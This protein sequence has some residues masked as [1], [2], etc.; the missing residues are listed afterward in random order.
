LRSWKSKQ[1]EYLDMCCA[2]NYQVIKLLLTKS[3][4]EYLIID[5]KYSKGNS[6]LVF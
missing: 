6:L 4:I 2:Y 1:I 3:W 5:R